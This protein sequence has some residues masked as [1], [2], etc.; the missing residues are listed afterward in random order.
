MMLVKTT[1]MDAVNMVHLVQEESGEGKRGN[2]CVGFMSTATAAAATF[3][4][5][6]LLLICDCVFALN[7]FV[8][9]EML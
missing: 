2:R 6:F 7:D 3:F 8:G 5:P 9:Q 1:Q 4:S